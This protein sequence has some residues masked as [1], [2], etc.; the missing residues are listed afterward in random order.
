MKY[1]ATIVF[2]SLFLISPLRAQ[3]DS[4]IFLKTEFALTGGSSYP[5]LP[6]DFADSWTKGWNAGFQTGILF[7]PGTLGYGS[8]LV[9]FD[10]NRFTFDN[11]KYRN[12][13]YQ[14]NILIS[15]NPTWAY[16]VMANVR[17]TVS[18][19]SERVHPFFLLG[20][21]VMNVSSGEITVGGDTTYTV[22]GK[23]HTMI[24]WDIGI[25]LDF[26]IT[27]QVGFFVET[28]SVLGVGDESNPTRQYFPVTGGLRIRFQR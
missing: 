17:G 14:N 15:K 19:W 10:A 6:K 7:K 13:L 26:P 12:T 28:R 22:E 20:F 2:I 5:Y 18:G 27:D 9:L 24:A 8:V 4:S 11:V 23:K 16:S 25:G 21:G 3:I 1:L